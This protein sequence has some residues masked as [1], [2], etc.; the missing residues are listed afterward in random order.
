MILTHWQPAK[1]SGLSGSTPSPAAV[2]DKLFTLMSSCATALD[3]DP[4]LIT[5]EGLYARK[6]SAVPITASYTR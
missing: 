6:V 1:S 4:T 3:L 2:V 5:G